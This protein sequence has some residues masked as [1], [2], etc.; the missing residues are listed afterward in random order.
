VVP[1]GYREQQGLPLQFVIGQTCLPST[2]LGATPAVFC[3]GQILW[4]HRQPFL[5]CC[6]G[7]LF[8]SPRELRDARF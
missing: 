1:V 5:S 7:M 3:G 2:L 8:F 4:T 6:G